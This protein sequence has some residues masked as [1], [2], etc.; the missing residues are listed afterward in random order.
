[1]CQ[2][3]GHD[4]VTGAVVT[5]Q[6]YLANDPKG[7][8]ILK[9]AQYVPPHER[10]DEEYPLFL[11]TG[12]V[13]YHFHTRTKTGRAE[14]LHQAMPDVFI[15]ISR[16]DADRYDISEGDVVEIESRRGKAQAPARIGDILPGHVFIP[17][18]F[19]YWDDPDHPRAA[20]ELTLTEWD[21]VSKQP[22]F[23]SAAVRLRKL[24]P[25]ATGQRMGETTRRVMEQARETFA[26]Q[27]ARSP[28]ETP[29]PS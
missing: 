3:Y 22:Y 28:S 20:N 14:A 8:A 17:F 13:V 2:T 21:P 4:L 1:V 16:E 5:R 26:S 19:G 7:K 29:W 25:V 10:P 27:E 23:K 9:P 6:E 18:H 24:V 15:Q 12:R 11:T